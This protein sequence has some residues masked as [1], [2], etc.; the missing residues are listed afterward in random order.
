MGYGRYDFWRGYEPEWDNTTHAT[1]LFTNE[2]I[3]IIQDH[4]ASNKEKSKPSPMFLYLSQSAPHDPLLP[5]EEHVSKC[6]HI[7]NR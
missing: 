6:N 5:T 7:T 3:K 1:T 2:A 4:S